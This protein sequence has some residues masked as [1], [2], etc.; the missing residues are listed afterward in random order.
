MLFS[1]VISNIEELLVFSI[2]VL[3]LPVTLDNINTYITIDDD[4]TLKHVLLM[5]LFDTI[6]FYVFEWYIT[7]IYP[8]EFG[9]PK[10]WYFPCQ[11]GKY[12]TGIYAIVV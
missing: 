2:Y 3:E 10:R 6:V 11:V 8:G 9:V 7:A 12:S 5:L 4:F 1:H